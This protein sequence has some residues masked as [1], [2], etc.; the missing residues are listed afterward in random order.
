M[1]PR[2]YFG[3]LAAAVMVVGF[4]DYYSWS[5]LESIGRP[6]DAIA[7]YQNTAGIAWTM[8]CVTSIVLAFVAC[9]VTWAGTR[10]WALWLTF[11]Y[12]S[13]FALF[14]GFVLDRAY[15]QL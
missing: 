4:F 7:G 10:A 13:I 6:E 8:L 15:Q 9:G 12:F 1:W 14:E 2:I 11:A 5:W 3:V